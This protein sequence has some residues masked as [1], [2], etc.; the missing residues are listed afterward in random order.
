MAIGV[1]AGNLLTAVVAARL[2]G[3]EDFGAFSIVRGTVYMMVS[4]AG[5]GIGLTAT[6]YIA[7]MKTAQPERLGKVLGLCELSAWGSGLFF[8]LLFLCLAPQ[9]AEQSLN[10]PQV[11]GQLRLASVYILFISFNFYQI[12]VLNGFEAF[13]PQAKISFVQALLSLVF[14]ASLTWWLALDGAALSLGLAAMANCILYQMAIHRELKS[15]NIVI[16]YRQLRSESDVL[17]GFTLPAALAAVIGALTMWSGS[18]CLVRQA[19]G[20]AQMAVFTAAGNVRSLIMFIPEL[21]TKVASPILCSLAG[22]QNQSGYS[23]V[24]WINLTIVAGSS[25]VVAVLLTLAGPWLMALFG[26]SFSNAGSAIVLA[27]AAGAVVEVIANTLYQPIYVRGRLWWQVGI[28]SAWGVALN[29][30]AALTAP[31]WGAL[32]LAAAYLAAH[33]LSGALYVLAIFR[34]EKGKI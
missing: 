19:D 13:L 12:G 7:E 28:I 18:A 5:L 34:L 17:S 8:A 23:R 32:G 14:T 22:E 20:L 4:I 30:I 33:L 27:V 15:W 10:A 2:L 29:G 25:L 26:R 3:I 31:V 1:S 21:V 24:F 9:I 6:R 11:T 16:Y